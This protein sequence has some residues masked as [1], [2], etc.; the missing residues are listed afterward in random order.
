[1]VSVLRSVTIDCYLW[2]VTINVREGRAGS[3]M[4]VLIKKIPSEM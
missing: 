1:M 2:G 4:V 3:L